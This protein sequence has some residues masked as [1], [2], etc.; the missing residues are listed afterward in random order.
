MY[1]TVRQ[2]KYISML[3]LLMFTTA[4]AE[5]SK[6][7]DYEIDLNNVVKD[8][9]QVSLKCQDFATD[10]LVFHFPLMIPG[11]YQEA[12]YGKFIHK[13]K[14]LDNQGEAIKPK[15]KGKNT[16]IIT[17]ANDIQKISY[18]VGATWDSRSRKTIWPMAGT[19]I[20]KDRL[21]A[22]NA[23]GVF[24]YFEGEELS[25][26]QMTYKYPEH[27]YAM[28]VLDQEAISPGMVAISTSDYHELI[29]SPIM[30]AYPDTA[31]FMIQ[32]AKVLIGF[33]HETDDTRR[34]G[35]LLEALEPSMQAIDSYLDS[36]PADKY[37][38]LIYYSNEYEL[39]RLI[40]N[41]RFMLLK[42]VWY[43]VRNGLPM[44]GALEH[45]KSSFY[46]LPDPGPGHTET[47]H[48][49]VEDISIHEFM[50][51]L[52]PLNL[53]SEYVDD[54]DYSD[55]RLSKH[56]WLYEGITE[57]MS[58]II[59]VNSGMETPKEFILGSMFYKLRRGENY[60]F[61]EVSFTEMSA[62]VLDKK[63]QKIYGQV[64][65]RG[66]VLGMLLDI[67]IIR[68]TEGKMRLIDVMFELID[69]YGQKQ[70]MDE[71]KLIDQFVE[72]VHPD[73]KVFFEK[74]VEGHEAL[75]YAEILDHVGV[76]YVADTSL[77]L[78]RHFT[79][80]NDV[81]TASIALGD[82]DIISKTGKEDHVGFEVN[83]YIGRHVYSDL[84]FD[85]FGI[86]LP[87]GMVVDLPVERD[88]EVIVL[89]DTVRY[90][91]KNRTHYMTIMRDATPQQERFFN[92]W[93]GFEEPGSGSDEE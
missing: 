8:R 88:G 2:F 43:F 59:Q 35:E 3:V 38:Y 26:V 13:L 29:D 23:G 11:T 48:K 19:G 87:E 14:V 10:T 69:D 53:R 55:P 60:P 40:D 58:K 62:N 76:S 51:I 90:M 21:F 17:P 33:A 34:A 75:P 46:Y 15:R 50:H 47:I 52:T 85:D 84:Y 89:P 56:L 7:Y 77:A 66:A 16:Y 57:Y 6:A 63:N 74:Y 32:D 82:H 65:E 22:I 1:R 45:N 27:L 9:Y 36:L 44:G 39:G 54:F 64:Y 31:S 4:F 81:K 18:W 78:P 28:T 91:E 79:R 86:A 25:P 61:A 24:G 73:L 42:A 71:D 67:E 12:N 70:A 20:I 83:D 80:D 92:I 72:K 41:P 49:T 37:A 5:N 30:F 68:L 93:L